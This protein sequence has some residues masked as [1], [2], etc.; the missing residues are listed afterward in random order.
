MKQ[1][2]IISGAS[3]FIGAALVKRFLKD[4]YTVY[5]LGRNARR[6]EHLKQCGDFIPI[7]LDLANYSDIHKLI[8]EDRYETFYH[9]AWDGVF[10]TAF[11]DHSLQLGNANHACEALMAAKKLGCRKFVLSGTSSQFEIQTK[12]KKGITAPRYTCIYASA[13]LVADTICATLAYQNGIDYSA[14]LICMAYGE[15]N[16]SNMLP[17]IVLTQLNHRT[18]PQLIAGNSAYDL[19]YIDDIVEAFV[20]IGRQGQNLRSYYVGHRQLNTFRELFTEI[21]DIV[22]PDVPLNFGAYQDTAD[23]DYSLIDLDALYRDTGF[24]CKADFRKS[25]LKTAQWLKSVEGKT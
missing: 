11:Q 13:K 20:C 7:I 1:K 9:F 4:G 21:R 23:M 5:G 14:G 22:A 2:V 15:N 3:G 24:E 10:G 17:N 6:L 18:A 19:I 16:R 12:L 8:P 25:I